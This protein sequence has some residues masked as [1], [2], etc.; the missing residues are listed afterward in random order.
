MA[1]LMKRSASP[2]EGEALSCTSR[3]LKV[4]KGRKR[5]KKKRDSDSLSSYADDS[6][7]G[8]S[9]YG[10]DL[11]KH[12][13]AEVNLPNSRFMKVLLYKTYWL[14]NRSTSEVWKAK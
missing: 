4:K 7:S 10:V 6:A 13:L 8:T 3:A 2:F 9:E 12:N 11:Q 1:F 14:G 5:S